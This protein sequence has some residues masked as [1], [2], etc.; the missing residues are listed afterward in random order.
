MRPLFKRANSRYWLILS[1]VVAFI[2]SQAGCCDLQLARR[3]QPKYPKKVR[4]WV[5]DPY[6]RRLFQGPFVLR[7]GESTENG[8]L[9]VRVAD[10]LAP[11]CSTRFAESPERAQVI[12]QFYD[13]S[14][15][16]V[17]CEAT[18]AE[19]S[20]ASIDREGICLGK[21]DVMVVGTAGVNTDEKWAVFDL[22]P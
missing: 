17:L 6:N 20:N 1:F 4:G 14:S 18:L 19:N 12:L 8:Q 15:K 22:R 2:T 9:G 16:Q 13:P 7:K 21:V 5:D 11:K 3:V 10:I